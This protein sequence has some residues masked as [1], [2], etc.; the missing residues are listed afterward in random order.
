M[1][2]PQE[3]REIARSE[4][5]DKT[6]KI[7]SG[8]IPGG[9][10]AYELFTALVQPLH[11]QRREEWIEDVTRRL[12]KLEQ[13]EKIDLKTLSESEEFNTIITRSTLLA[14]QTHQEK[15][16]KA[17]SKIVTNSSLE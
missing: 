7:I 12:H 3:K 4:A 9:S 6:A 10:S 17:L 14:I 2:S 16:K 8:L 13:E 11:V 1:A 15:K 5:R